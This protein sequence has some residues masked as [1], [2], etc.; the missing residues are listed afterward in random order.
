MASA[1]FFKSCEGY[2]DAKITRK[3]WFLLKF[4]VRLMPNL[5]T[6]TCLHLGVLAQVRYWRRQGCVVRTG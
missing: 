4:N 3:I 1:C 5:R 2:I 6:C